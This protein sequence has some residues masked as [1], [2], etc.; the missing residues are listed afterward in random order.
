MT[1]A[2]YAGTDPAPSLEEAWWYKDGGDPRG[3]VT[4]VELRRLVEGGAL[5]RDALV[6][7]DGY[8]SHWRRLDETGVRLGEGPPP[9]DHGPWA[10]VF[11]RIEADPKARPGSWLGF[12]LGPLAYFRYGMWTRGL[13][14]LAAWQVMMLAVIVA[15]DAAGASLKGLPAFPLMIFCAH[16][17]K[18]D[19]YRFKVLGERVWP[20]FRRL[21]N[22]PV[23]AAA[24]V[25]L[26]LAAGC[27][28]LANPV[29]GLSTEVAGVWEGDGFDVVVDTA[30]RVKTIDYEGTRYQ[31]RVRSF[32]DAN[33]VIVFADTR[34]PDMLL[35]FVKHL[36]EGRDEGKYSLD[37]RFNDVPV[38]NLRYLRPA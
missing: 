35:T 22:V 18:R 32:D 21:D 29:D 27:A 33:G 10:K 8:G 37:F 26:F 20:R 19:Y 31:V 2:A 24:C 38:G 5:R 34:D 23:C 1:S 3:P 9:A 14:I 11:A 16:N 13:L 15:E 12:F 36:E 6:W 25:A 17:L 4:A 28:E 30:G 7:T